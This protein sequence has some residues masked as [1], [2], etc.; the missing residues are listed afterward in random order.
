[1]KS[2]RG[3]TAAILFLSALP[4]AALYQGLAGGGGE[5]VIHFSIAL[6]S[7]LL[8]S[9]IHDFPTS[10]WATWL[11]RLSTGPLAIIF[12]LQGTSEL[13]RSD[14]LKDVAFRVLGQQLEGW[15]LT[16]L[17]VWCMTVVLSGGHGKTKLLGLIAVSSAAT[18]R[19]YATI[20][21]LSGTSL[22]AAAPALKLLYLMPFVWLLAESK[23][24]AH[25][26]EPR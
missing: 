20:L 6:G 14:R 23:R 10:L 9:A 22:E 26:P 13:T 18:V 15:L 1:M 7:G 19:A 11:G 8:C 5:T 2:P 24:R 16:G 21:P 17:L 4:L 3:F 25:G 12:A